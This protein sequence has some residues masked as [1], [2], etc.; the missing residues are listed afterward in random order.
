MDRILIVDD[1]KPIR[2]ILKNLF[3][4]EGY[5]VIL[6]P[7]GRV[8]LECQRK[9]PARLVIMDL[10]MPEK[11][12]IETILE[13]KEKYPDVK[14]IAISGFASDGLVNLLESARLFGAEKTF[15]K[16]FELKEILEAARDLLK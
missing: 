7:D 6:A 11:E 10:F 3:T 13:L 8:A 5:E 2:D 4:R 14:I 12:G 15:I 16:P 9:A 1:D